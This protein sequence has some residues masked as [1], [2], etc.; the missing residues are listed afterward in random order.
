[1]ENET[2]NYDRSAETRDNSSFNAAARQR[3]PTSEELRAYEA[4]R[5]ENPVWYEIL[6]E[7]GAGM[8]RILRNGPAKED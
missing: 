5:E 7:W 6:D 8:K 4:K 1:M 3:L 2:Q